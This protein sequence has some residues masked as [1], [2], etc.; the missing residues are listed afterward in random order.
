M[1]GIAGI[2]RPGLDPVSHGLIRAMTD[3]IAHRGPDG[4]GH[5]VDADLALGHR[6]LAILDLT[7]AGRQPMSTSDGRYVVVFNGEIYNHA[8]LRLQLQEKGH[9]FHSRTDTEVLL[10]G[11]REWGE[12]IIPKLNGMF[13]F[14]LWDKKERS[15]LLARDRYGVKPLYFW[16]NGA[17][18]VFASEIKAILKHPGYKMAVN[19]DALNE[20]FTFQNLFRFHTLF[21]GIELVRPAQLMRIDRK[22]SV[23][24]RVYWDYNFTDRN[25]SMSSE[26]ACEQTLSLFKQAVS[27]QMMA[28]VRVGSYLSG[29]MDSGSITAVA[30]NQ[31]QRLATFTCGF[32]MSAVSGREANFDERRDAELMS[33]YFK[34]EHYEQVINAGDIA[35]SMPRVVWHIEDLR[36]GMSYPNYYIS[37]LASK[38]VKVC[39]TGAGGD[40]LY[41][42]Y[43]WRYYRVL[44]SMDQEAFFK[45]YYGF[46][47][48]L[49]PDEDKNQLFTADTLRATSDVR[50]PYD[51]F[52]RVFTFNDSL[53]YDNPEDHIANCLYFEA[54]TFLH[55]LFLL[56]D[57]LSMAS[58]LEERVP[59]MDNDLVEFA[60]RIPIQ[61]KLANLEKMK[62]LDENEA[63]K[64][65]RFQL[66]F[67][68]GKN[69]LRRAMSRLIPEQIINRQKQGFSAPDESWYRGENLQYVKDLLMGKR[70]ASREFLN[71]AYVERIITEHSEK[72]INHRLLIWSML[73]F[74]WWCKIFLEGVPVDE[75]AG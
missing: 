31:T 67:D 34:T 61:H 26:E 58:S 19:H 18:L 14:A 3:A 36:L 25:L 41:G 63:G 38:F 40:E 73:S 8:E 60:Q 29:G 59:F 4:E 28:D 32:D 23:S 74:E 6:R 15:L 5:Y 27:R 1:C 57:K 75:R 42:G 11:Y 16:K 30:H 22:G 65:R 70:A 71:P 44:H 56:G 48:R 20:Y 55:A 45:E 47:Q 7:D 9:Q 43:P 62:K 68:D 53:K 69:A 12:A 49:V 10:H 33:S 37:R 50:D 46:W 66:Q 21:A 64:L 35:W 24:S 52:R 51:I 2:Y 17:E 39:L 72:G 13:A 54:K